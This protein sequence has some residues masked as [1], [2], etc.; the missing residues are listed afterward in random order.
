V[1]EKGIFLKINL[2]EM[3][4]SPKARTYKSPM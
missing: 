3:G 1:E 4:P 2:T